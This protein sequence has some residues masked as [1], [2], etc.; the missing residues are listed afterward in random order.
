MFCSGSE[1]DTDTYLGQWAG[2][3]SQITF[4]NEFPCNHSRCL[5]QKRI[6][7]VMPKW[8]QGG[9]LFLL[10]NPMIFVLFKTVDNC[11]HFDAI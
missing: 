10:F 1:T 2:S 5:G 4:L 8:E 6:N 9:I 11:F 7:E 3:C